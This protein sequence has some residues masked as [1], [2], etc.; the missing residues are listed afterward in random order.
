[1]VIT[2]FLSIVTASLAAGP[3]FHDA[4][5]W[6]GPSFDINDQAQ[7]RD[8]S[9]IL[10]SQTMTNDNIPA[11]NLVA[12][13]WS[14][15]AVPPKL[16]RGA[17]SSLV[18]VTPYQIVNLALLAVFPNVSVHHHCESYSETSTQGNYTIAG[19]D[20]SL[21][22]RALFFS[23]TSEST[24]GFG[25]DTDFR[26]FWEPDVFNIVKWSR[27]AVG[28]GGK[29]CIQ[30]V[31]WDDGGGSA[32]VSAVVSPDPFVMDS[33]SPTAQAT[34]PTLNPDRSVPWLS[35]ETNGPSG[36]SGESF[37]TLK[38]DDL[39]TSI[40]TRKIVGL[41]DVSL[42]NSMQ[43]I[44]FGVNSGIITSANTCLS[45]AEGVDSLPYDTGISFSDTFVVLAG[46][47]SFGMTDNAGFG[48][49][50]DISFAITVQNNSVTIIRGTAGVKADCCFFVVDLSGALPPMGGATTSPTSSTSATT[51]DTSTATTTGTSST[52][53]ATTTEPT[54]TSDTSTSGTTTSPGTTTETTTTVDTSTAS[55][56]PVD[57]STS[58]GST[59]LTTTS[60]TAAPTVVGPGQ[61][62]DEPSF[63]G[64]LEM[65]ADSTLQVAFGTTTTV[66]GVLSIAPGAILSLANV[67]GTDGRSLRM[68]GVNQTVVAVS[69]GAVSGT[70]AS[71]VATPSDACQTATVQG[72]TYSATTVSVAINVAGDPCSNEGGGLSTGAI[73]GIAIGAA[74]AGVLLIVIVVLLTIRARNNRTHLMND[75]IKMARLPE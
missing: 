4:P 3:V 1:M 10:M 18:L 66:A 56:L 27:Q 47:G 5:A 39:S 38:F 65:A 30:A 58:T 33:E 41:Q 40:V 60:T 50:S 23:W 15:A 28:A 20:F 13:D 35:Y 62:V 14:S 69:A 75:K 46:Q 61:T 63:P 34:F 68:A 45:F 55:T 57:T 48:S 6:D 64:D 22:R 67:V 29:M 70:F 53:T 74:L 42:I 2:L 8:T 11:E 43:V 73:I 59:S 49:P 72:A 26:V 12:I 71:V 7:A 37:A 21:N 54:S 9:I 32:A 17:S 52:T 24:A 16:I 44:D 19:P 25:N 36:L 51:V 31:R